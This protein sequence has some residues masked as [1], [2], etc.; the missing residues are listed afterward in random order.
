MTID[1]RNQKI[2]EKFFELKPEG[3]TWQQDEMFRSSALKPTKFVLTP[4]IQHQLA[5]LR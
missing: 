2:E 5:I 4:E 1:E 3:E